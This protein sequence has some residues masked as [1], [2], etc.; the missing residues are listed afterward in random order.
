MLGFRRERQAASIAH[1]CA[2][3][4]LEFGRLAQSEPAKSWLRAWR[5]DPQLLPPAP[6]VHHAHSIRTA[7]AAK[8]QCWCR[9]G[10]ACPFSREAMAN[11]DLPGRVKEELTQIY[12]LCTQ[13]VTHQSQEAH[14][15]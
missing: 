7:P 15:G 14:H 2:T 5:V 9:P 4:L 1:G 6:P 10:I 13:N 3:T 11:T 12:Q 8:G